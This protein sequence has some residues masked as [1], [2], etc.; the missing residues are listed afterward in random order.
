MKAPKIT[1]RADLPFIEM[2]RGKSGNVSF[3]FNP[4]KVTFN[5]TNDYSA[6]DYCTAIGYANFPD[7]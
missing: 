2:V 1:L 7:T 3:S 5:V 6:Y 4:P